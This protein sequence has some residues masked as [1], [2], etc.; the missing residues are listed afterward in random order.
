MTSASAVATMWLTDS[1][2]TGV[3]F[4]EGDWR[5]W[6]FRDG[7]PAQ[8]EQRVDARLA[9]LGIGVDQLPATALRFALAGQAVST[10][11]V[12]MRSLA[13]VER[14]AAVAEAPPLTAEELAL[15][16]KHRWQKNFYS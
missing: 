15:L 10:V 11:I 4:P 9:D 14:D 3:A 7:R 8:V 12:G 13:N 2:R 6:Y 1:I 5:N 16:A